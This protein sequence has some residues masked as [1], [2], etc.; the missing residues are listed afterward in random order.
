MNTT[1]TIA[2]WAGVFVLLIVLGSA[3]YVVDE[4]EQVIVTQFGKPVG[5]TVSKPGIHLKLPFIQQANYF[6][7]RYLEWDGDRNQVPTKD[8]KF[9]FVDSYARWEITDPLKF[10][11]RLRDETGAQSR[12]DDILDGETRNAIASH[13]LLEVVRSSNRQV[14]SSAIQTDVIDITLEDIEIGRD[15]IQVMI[16]KSANARSSDLGIEI[17]D[18]RFKRIKY[19]EEVQQRV[20]ERMISERNR[21]AEKFR[22]EGRGEAASIAG[23]REKELNSIESQA[24]KIAA[25]TRGKADA[26]AASIY[27][28]AYNRNSSARDLYEF[29]KTMETYQETF[30]D[31]T[32]VILSTDS[33]FYKYLKSID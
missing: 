32:S 10:F 29:V 28:R 7:N 20:Y 23:E 3:M 14:D 31:E 25:E 30:S 9:I 1:K 19:V 18:F 27:N 11:Q 17:L 4:T 21:I 33:E 6:D 8:K 12:L 24:M 22:S 16:L 26:E 2:L 5:E 15:S 13:D